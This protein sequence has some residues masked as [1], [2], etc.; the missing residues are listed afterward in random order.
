M[1]ESLALALEGSG[2]PRAEVERALLSAA[3][4]AS[5]PI[6]LLSLASYFARLGSKKQSLRIC[7]QVVIFE[8]DCRKLM[9]WVLSWPRSLMIQILCFGRVLV[10]SPTNGQ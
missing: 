2:R 1:Y 6:D 5:T 10:C 8:P 9:L 7:K 4:L 3:D